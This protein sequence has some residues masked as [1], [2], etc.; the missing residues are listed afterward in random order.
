MIPKNEL[1]TSHTARRSFATNL[2]LAGIDT[3]S[4]MLLTGHKTEKSF[5]VYIR[6]TKEQNAYRVASHPFFK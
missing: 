6:I 2:Y 5:M 1:V 4:I 3:I